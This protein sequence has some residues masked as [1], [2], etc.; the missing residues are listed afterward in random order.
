ML[1]KF[2]GLVALSVICSSLYA[3][4]V[5]NDD[6]KKSLRNV[7]F[8]ES[9]N[10]KE[11]TFFTDRKDKIRM[12][13]PDDWQKK[14]KLPPF[15]KFGT[16]EFYKDIETIMDLKKLRT[17]EMVRTI[18]DERIATAFFIG[19]VHIADLRLY[20]GKKDPL[21]DFFNDVFTD[22]DVAL[23][24][25]KKEYN[26]GRPVDIIPNWETAIETPGHASYPC[27][28]CAESHIF[29][30]LMTE[31]E[32]ELKDEF[33]KSAGEISMHREIAGVHFHSDNEAGQLLAKQVFDLLKKSPKWKER[34]PIV[35][36]IWEERRDMLLGKPFRG[37]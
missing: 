33:F 30:H 18:R 5:L 29:A 22:I 11:D 8:S 1:K 26:R 36:K 23:Y 24:T 13:L 6:V 19:P 9:F 3:Q 7:T 15:P 28:H 21:A 35:K 20:H 31:F 10:L 34:F 4:A 17:P 25:L 27:G 2:S 37:H 16:A 12:F 14:V 32:P